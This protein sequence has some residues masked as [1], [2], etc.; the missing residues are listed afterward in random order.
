MIPRVH[1]VTDASVLGRPDFLEVATRVASAG[2]V[3][4]HLRDRTAPATRLARLAEAVVPALQERGATLFI[5]ARPDI[6]R[7]VGANGVQLGE[8]DLGVADARMVFPSGLIGRSV[9]DEGG[10]R[11]ATADEAD[12]LMLGPVWGT[13][14]HPG[15][16]ALGLE[17]VRRIARPQTLD[18][19]PLL[20]IGGVTPERAREARA[21]GA[22][23]I[24]AIRAIWNAPDP[25]RAVKEFLEV[26]EAA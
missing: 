20:L 4:I 12:F 14:T 16:A 1:A 13:E 21:A 3:A 9:H 19:G 5:N 6:A 18:P 15:S 17:V 25:A 10:A 26:M 8:R 24:A 7:A 22:H 11:I 2:N 23:G